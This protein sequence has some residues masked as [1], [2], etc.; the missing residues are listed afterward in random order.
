MAANTEHA[1]DNHNHIH[2]EVQS[3]AD[4]M[5]LPTNYKQGAARTTLSD[6][7]QKKILQD[8]KLLKSSFSKANP[9][10]AGVAAVDLAK[11]TKAAK[12]SGGVR[13]DSRLA[14]GS[15]ATVAARHSRI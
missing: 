15:N 13:V 9:N 7:I 8:R 1:N 3:Y 2:L 14:P 6:N 11:M 10:V 12:P 5:F 4:Q